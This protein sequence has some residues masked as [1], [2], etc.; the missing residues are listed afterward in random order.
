MITSEKMSSHSFLKR[1]HNRF[2]KLFEGFPAPFC[3]NRSQTTQDV[4][5]L[6]EKCMKF[7]RPA[8]NCFLKRLF[9][10]WLATILALG[11]HILTPKQRKNGVPKRRFLS[12]RSKN[13]YYV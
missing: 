10:V 1:S 2:Q 6:P 9:F 12:F 8:A 7:Q 4:V 5:F 13:R 11:T 3:K